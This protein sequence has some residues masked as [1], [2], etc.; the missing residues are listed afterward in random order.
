LQ[1]AAVGTRIQTMILKLI[2]RVVSCMKIAPQNVACKDQRVA[3]A[4]RGSRD[5]KDD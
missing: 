5:G 2:S 3:Y 4:L 1:A